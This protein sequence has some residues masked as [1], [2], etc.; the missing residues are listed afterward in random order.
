[1]SSDSFLDSSDLTPSKLKVIYQSSPSRTKQPNL[2]IYEDDT[3]KD[4]YIKLAQITTKRVSSDMIVAWYKHK[5]K[6]HTCHPA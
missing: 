5:Q 6:I 3:C 4:I 2:V 1:M